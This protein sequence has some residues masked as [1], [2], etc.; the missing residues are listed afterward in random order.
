MSTL[1]SKLGVSSSKEDV[2]EAMGQLRNSS[3][4]TAFCQVIDDGSQYYQLLHADG[5]GSKSIVAYL[6]YKETGSSKIFESLAIDSS[7]MNTD[8]MLCVG[9]TDGFILSNTIGRNSHRVGKDILASIMLGYQHFA[10]SMRPFGITISLCGGETADV[11]DIISTLIVDSTMYA[12]FPKSRFI[13]AGK[14]NQNPNNVIVG[15]SSFGK[16]SYES[17]INSGIGSNGFTVARHELLSKKYG[18]KFPETFSNTINP[19]SVYNGQFSLSDA[20]PG[21]SQTVGDALLSP[22]RT[23][24]PVMAKVFDIYGDKI[25]S[26]IHNTGGG[27]TKSLN[28]SSG[29]HY[30]K[31]NLFD[32]P[33]IFEAIKNNSDTNIKDMWSVFNCGQRLEISCDSSVAA[34]IIEISQS[35]GVEAKIIG[36]TEPLK[37]SS[38]NK[39]SISHNGVTEE[40]VKTL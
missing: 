29:M 18:E 15:L 22:C 27:I 7:V 37:D 9:C 2:H 34:G 4:A 25:R 19:S 35:L 28:F 16:A 40:Y 31:D 23:Y 36:Y 8:D 5:A 20:L 1:Y 24:L 39:V 26:V 11:G 30:I 12:R 14:I 33:P 32:L 6:H 17:T 10:D 13:D 38:T 3:D 21:S